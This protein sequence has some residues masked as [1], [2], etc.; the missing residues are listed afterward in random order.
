MFLDT[1][2]FETRANKNKGNSFR[3]K[4]LTEEMSMMELRKFPNYCSLNIIDVAR[5]TPIT[6]ILQTLLYRLLRTLEH[7]ALMPSLSCHRL[8]HAR[9]W[10]SKT[11]VSPILTLGLPF[12]H[13]GRL[14]T[15]NILNEELVKCLKRNIQLVKMAI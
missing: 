8:H 4:T 5:F 7:Y 3:D 6:R 9:D 11:I 1:W 12:L 15:Q 14:K 10:H 13:S 2:L